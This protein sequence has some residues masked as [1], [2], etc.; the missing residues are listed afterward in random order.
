MVAT[1]SFALRII[2]TYLLIP[3]F[4]E[5]EFLLIG[6]VEALLQQFVATL[7]RFLVSTFHGGNRVLFLLFDAKQVLVHLREEI[8]NGCLGSDHLFFGGGVAV[9]QSWPFGVLSGKRRRSE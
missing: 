6:S 8:L 3:L 1:I 7:D 5:Q 9:G 4:A 2:S